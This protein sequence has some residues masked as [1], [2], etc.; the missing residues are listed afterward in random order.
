MVDTSFSGIE[1]KMLAEK[2]GLKY[3]YNVDDNSSSIIIPD[4]IPVLD[5]DRVFAICHWNNNYY[6]CMSQF[7]F[8][9][10]SD[11]TEKNAIK[12]TRM[13]DVETL[14]EIK[15][16]LKNFKSFLEMFGSLRK[17]Y[18]EK[19]KLNKLETDF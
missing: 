18:N 17:V 14:D 3:E 19:I 6:E 4:S 13:D 7:Q 1:I 16:N 15:T 5:N 10:S 12:T 11:S 9:F 2:Y 8:I